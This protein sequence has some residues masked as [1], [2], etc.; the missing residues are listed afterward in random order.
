MLLSLVLYY[1]LPNCRRGERGEEGIK[2]RF[3]RKISGISIHYDPPPPPPPI[4]DFFYQLLP[5][6]P[7]NYCQPP[8]P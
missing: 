5:P 7:R 1:P 8:N 4:N 6:L 2:F 3:L